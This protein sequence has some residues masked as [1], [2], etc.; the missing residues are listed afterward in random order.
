MKSVDQKAERKPRSDGVD[1]RERLLHVA[2]RLFAEKGYAKTSTRQIAQTAEVN[3]AS[4]SYYFGDKAGLYRAV[5]TEPMGCSID[6]RAQYDQSHFTLRESLD[7]LFRGILAPMHQGDLMQL[8]TRLHY[9][10]ML[11][12]TGV[13]AE[14]IDNGIKPAHAALVRVLCRHLAVSK[15]DDD[16][17]R[18]AFSVTGL[19]LQIFIT[20]DVIDAIRPKLLA[21]TSAIDAWTARLVDFAEVMVAQE[22]ARRSVKPI[23]NKHKKS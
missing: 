10:E 17:H 22:A 9:R 16:V 21:S 8:C 1:A 6:D 13:W 18:L 5:F 19:A 7:G 23:L 3:I 15:A 14:Q 12:P 2:L 4:I 20:R 11:E